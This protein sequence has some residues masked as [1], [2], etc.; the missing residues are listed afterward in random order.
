MHVTHSTFVL[1][2]SNK[3]SVLFLFRQG[4]YRSPAVISSPSRLK[5]TPPYHRFA[6]VRAALVPW[7]S[8]KKYQAGVKQSCLDR[9]ARDSPSGPPRHPSVMSVFAR[10]ASNRRPILLAALSHSLSNNDAP[11]T[12]PSHHH[13]PSPTTPSCPTSPLA[14]RGLFPL[15]SFVQSPSSPGRR[16]IHV[17]PSD[18]C[19]KSI[20]VGDVVVVG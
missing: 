16:P 18:P 6:V 20:P 15:A 19:P 4:Q 2:A 12:P 11:R 17:A 10:C 8:G 5:P 3:H 1:C 13:K 14:S 9:V 7:H